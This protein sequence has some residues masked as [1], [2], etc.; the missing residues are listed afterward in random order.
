[1]LHFEEVPSHTTAARPG[2]EFNIACV[3]CGNI[4]HEG[5]NACTQM[6]W[7]TQAVTLSL[8][9]FRAVPDKAGCYCG[10][11]IMQHSYHKH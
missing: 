9:S 2:N 11:K 1:M 3:C 7:H 8:S 6:R 4:I 5:M 10:I